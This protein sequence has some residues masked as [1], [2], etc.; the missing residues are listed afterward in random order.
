M[1]RDNG[2]SDC[3]HTNPSTIP[4]NHYFSTSPVPHL[5]TS[6]PIWLSDHIVSMSAEEAINSRIVL[7]NTQ[8]PIFLMS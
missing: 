8:E 7:P 4:T 2:L 3:G 1:G 5:G 6:E